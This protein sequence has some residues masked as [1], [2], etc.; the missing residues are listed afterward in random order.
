VQKGVAARVLEYANE[1]LAQAYE[2]DD[3]PDLDHD[4]APDWFIAKKNTANG[5][6]LV[7]WDPEIALIEDG[8]VYPDGLEGCNADDSSLCTCSANRACMELERYV[9]VPFFLRQALDAY[10]LV[11]PEAKGIY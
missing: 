10:G 7:R 6:P 3:G 1:L 5:Q 2:V 8:Y 11:D 9:E 4:G